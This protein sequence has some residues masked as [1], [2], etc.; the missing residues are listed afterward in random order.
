MKD[1]H[2]NC[3]RIRYIGSDSS[4]LF[5]IQ[6]GDFKFWTGDGFSRVLDM[7]K[8]FH[9]HDSAATAV[10]ALQYQ[11]YKGKPVRAF[12]L[13]LDI[14]LAAD[15]IEEISMEALAAYIRKSLKLNVDSVHGDGPVEG[16]FVQARLLVATLEETVPRRERF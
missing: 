6:R 12:K 15:G 5:T 1:K 11:Q 9:D 10:A 16:S 14:V 2:I 4:R 3:L 7:A 8:I 13:E